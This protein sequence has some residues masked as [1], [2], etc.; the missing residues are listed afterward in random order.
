MKKIA[1]LVVMM[2]CLSLTSAWANKTRVEV[3]A[4]ATIKA[5]TEVTITI[6][7]FHSANSK[8]HHTDW[9]YLKVNGKEVKRWEYNKE[10]LPPDSNFTLEYKFIATEDMT[11]EAEGHCNLHGSAGVANAS[12]KITQ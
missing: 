1:L 9:V 3:K 2:F 6:N 8:M 5:G 4:P 12:V 10:S 11:L 7:V